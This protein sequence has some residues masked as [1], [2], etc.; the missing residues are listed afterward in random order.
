[1]VVCPYDQHDS[2]TER[3]MIPPNVGMTPQ[4]IVPRR[5]SQAL[6]PAPQR[7][8]PLDPGC[9]LLIHADQTVGQTA[10]Q[11]VPDSAVEAGRRDGNGE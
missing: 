10:F 6:P 8:H 11:Q 2:V 5:G 7:A 3:T 1:M 4:I 9:V